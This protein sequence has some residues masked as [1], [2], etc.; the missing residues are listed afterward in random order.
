MGAR[1]HTDITIRGVTYPTVAAAAAVLSVTPAAIYIAM[2]KGTLHRVGT[3]RVGPEPMPVRIAGRDFADARQAARH[4]GITYQAVIA[5]ICA[6]DPDRIARRPVYGK[7]RAQEITLAGV[8]FP[9]KAA[10]SRALGFHENYIA[11]SLSRGGPSTLRKIEQAAMRYAMSRDAQ[12]VKRRAI[13]RDRADRAA[14]RATGE[15][16]HV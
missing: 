6:G 14:A 3:G 8:T 5:A 11:Q 12:Q 10:A 1:K 13:Q 9:S 7:A 4:F 16:A 2:R 15:A